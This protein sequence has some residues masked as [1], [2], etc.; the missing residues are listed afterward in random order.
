MGD[1]AVAI[2]L[3]ALLLEAPATHRFAQRAAKAAITT[4]ARSP[5]S[6]PLGAKLLEAAPVLDGDAAAAEAAIPDLEA[7]APDPDAADAPE[8]AVLLAETEAGPVLGL[9]EPA[10]Y[11]SKVGPVMLPSA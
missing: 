2:T 10:V 11:C 6:S 5:P 3:R 8:E 1:F 9:I 7:E 4:A